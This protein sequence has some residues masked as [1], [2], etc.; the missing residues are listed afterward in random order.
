[1]ATAFVW[2]MA[3]FFLGMGVLGLLAPAAIS[4][5]FGIT[6]GGADGRTEVRAVYGGF[7]VAIAVL[8]AFGAAGTA[9]LRPGAVIA[10]AVALLGMALG[11]LL[12]TVVDRP[13]GFFPTWLYFLVELV[14]GAGLLAAA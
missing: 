2:L 3:V 12:S 5:Q 7:G 9:G 14:G 13:A 1:M 10:V 6:L 8:L 4:G 11:R